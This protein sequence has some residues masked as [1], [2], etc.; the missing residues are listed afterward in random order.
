MLPPERKRT[1]SM[2]WPGAFGMAGSCEGGSS[3]PSAIGWDPDVGRAVGIDLPEGSSTPEAGAHAS[4]TE[5]T[6]SRASSM[7]FEDGISGSCAWIV[8]LHRD[9]R[10]HS[11]TN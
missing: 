5:I 9:R 4:P 8:D 1:S 10:V 3:S 7:A 11:F 2:R 6:P